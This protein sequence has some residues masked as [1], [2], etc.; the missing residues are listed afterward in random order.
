MNVLYLLIPIAL[1]LG[2]LSLVAFLFAARS[3]Q[4][5]NLDTPPLKALIDETETKGSR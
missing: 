2:I 4:M 1:G 5:E 3:G